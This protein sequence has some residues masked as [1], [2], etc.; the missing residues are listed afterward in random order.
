MNRNELGKRDQQRRKLIISKGFEASFC[1]QDRCH[2]L[3]ICTLRLDRIVLKDSHQFFLCVRIEFKRSQGQGLCFAVDR[4]RN[5]IPC[6]G[7]HPSWLSRVREEHLK[8]V[9]GLPPLEEDGWT[10]DRVD[11][12]S[13]NSLRSKVNFDE[14]AVFGEV[15]MKGCGCFVTLD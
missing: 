15:A 9:Q 2:V 3:R 7:T 14:D 12:P 6:P 1:F 11:E 13:F 10:L 4:M 5:S 8:R